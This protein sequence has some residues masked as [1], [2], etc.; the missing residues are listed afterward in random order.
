MIILDF[1][2]TTSRPLTAFGSRDVSFIPVLK[3]TSAGVVCMRVAPGGTIAEHPAAANQLFLVVE[4]EGWVRSAPSDRVHI[5]AGQAA[6]WKQGE[7]H[8]AG[9]ATGLVAIIVEGAGLL[10]ELPPIASGS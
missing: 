7:K 9:S 2:D 6:L 1:S 5:K 4:G 10:P 3:P 8:E